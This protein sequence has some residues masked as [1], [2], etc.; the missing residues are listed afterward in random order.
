MRKY[1]LIAAV[2][3][4]IPLIC[5]T[6]RAIGISVSPRTAL[7][8]E[9]IEVR[10]QLTFS[11]TPAA[12]RVRLD[13]GDGS[14]TQTT[15]ICNTD[16]TLMVSHVFSKRGTFT[17]SATSV[18]C[19]QSPTA[20]D[21]ARVTVTI[22]R[23]SDLPP[24]LPPPLTLT[25]GIVGISYRQNLPVQQKIIAAGRHKPFK[26]ALLQGKLPPG[27]FMTPQ[28]LLKGTPTREGRYRFSVQLTDRDGFLVN[29]RYDLTVIRTS[30]QVR[31]DPASFRTVREHTVSL[32]ISYRFK[33]PDP[34]TTTL[35]SPKGEFFVN[36][37]VGEVNRP[38]V[39]KMVKGRATVSETITIPAVVS[40]RAQA[41]KTAAVEYRRTFNSTVMDSRQ[42]RV[43]IRF[44]REGAG[45][46]RVTRIRIYFQNGRPKITVKRNQRDL[47]VNADV[48]YEGT[49]LLKGYFEVDGRI[50]HRV[51]RHVVYGRSTGFNSVTF[52]T[53]MANV[54]P[55]FATGSH[56]VRFVVEVPDEGIAFPHAV[57]FVTAQS[58][59]PQRPI[60][61]LSPE[62]G[63]V[64]DG[65]QAQ[66]SWTPS[67]CYRTYRI[68]FFTEEKAAPFFSALCRNGYYRLPTVV[69]RTHFS[70]G[71]GYRWQVTGYDENHHITGQSAWRNF[72]FAQPEVNVPGQL[73][74]V[75][76]AAND[77]SRQAA[78]IANQFGL[79]LLRVFDLKPL[80]QRIALFS[81]DRPV[82][83]TMVSMQKHPGIV[84]VQPNYVYR[85]FSDPMGDMQRLG[86]LLKF[87]RLHACCTGRGVRVAVV[88]TGVDDGHPD[89]QERV[90]LY[91]D[92]VDGSNDRAEVHGTAVA[93]VIAAAVNGVGIEGLAPD[94]ELLALRACRQL[95]S[96][97]PEGECH[98]LA[99]ARAISRALEAGVHIVN[100]SFGA[101]VIDDLIIRLIRKGTARGV[102]FVAPAGNR[103]DQHTATFPASDP[104]VISVAGTDDNGRLLPN[105][106]V[107]SQC[108]ALAPAVDI[109]TTVPGN[110]HRFLSGTSIASA[111]VTGLL[112]NAIE[113]H[114]RQ[115]SRQLPPGDSDLCQWAQSL[116][117]EQFCGQ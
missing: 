92:F 71:R 70:P 106:V 109:L 33:S 98:T 58:A 69:V 110:R 23:S 14:P 39:V 84:A 20:P 95:S 99:I 66:F 85:T 62:D 32:K 26:F 94:A 25:P 57:Y 13:F 64:I 80:G 41:L 12:C 101:G 17:I 48:R 45:E 6:A 81:T 31:V 36:P 38:L 15:S 61:L 1:S 9:P 7:V 93:G 3:L 96:Q 8:G 51:Q 63:A 97:M 44:V 43:T 79:R 28:G 60:T 112:T 18:A 102:F 46:L 68:D 87:D 37:K 75:L 117:G 86:R 72:S 82:L 73:L 50:I 78:A 115:M 65:G 34:I 56:V 10:I 83:D 53:P 103:P 42:T 30:F 5:T 100:M 91:E 19:R 88:D 16:C 74:A 35:R 54:L 77:D 114:G 111:V 27:I 89:L 52:R 2:L 29:Q 47:R 108:D 21:P 4:S 105:T 11:A 59:V 67:G 24:L 107:A 116:I 55:T 104:D 22:H 40:R 113:K 90:V 49:G 76:A